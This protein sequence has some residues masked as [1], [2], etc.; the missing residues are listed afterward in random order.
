MRDDAEQQRLEELASFVRSRREGLK[1]E[2]LGL[3]VRARRRTPG[4]RR[5]EVAELVGISVTWYT[6]LEQARPISVSGDVLE[7]LAQ[8]FRLNGDER[9]YLYQLAGRPLPPMSLESHEVITPAFQHILNT[10]EPSPAHIRDFGWNVLAWN[11]AETLLVDWGAYPP[12]ERNIIWHHFA[13]PLF[14]QIMVNWEREA[15]S[16]LSE[17][18][19]ESGQ[20][21]EDQ[22]YATLIQELNDISREFRQWWP[23][24][25]IRR[26][27]EL[28]VELQLPEME[29]LIF[30]PVTL[31]FTSEARLLMRIL[32]PLPE[33][34]TESKLRQLLD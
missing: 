27:R 17:F 30:Q 20:N 26:E 16:V 11:K 4:L 14:R 9:A 12:D 25:E 29:Y 1:P 15:R 32:V 6:W 19:M 8:L 13:N 5:E 2:D 28:P 10:L 34:D 18:R 23:L 33:T 3:S 21:T 22:R 7:N 24:H 31:A